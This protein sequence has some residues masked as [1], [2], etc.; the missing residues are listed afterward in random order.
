M[1]PHVLIVIG[2]SS[3]T[4]AMSKAWGTVYGKSH[5]PST[6]FEQPGRSNL[7]IRAT[8]VCTLILN[9]LTSPQPLTLS[10]SD[11]GPEHLEC[12]L[13][14]ENLSRTDW[15]LLQLIPG[16][17]VQLFVVCTLPLIYDRN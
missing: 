11:V 13:S 4:S 15:A 3:Y 14:F 16:I 6:C 2:T 12:T 5:P 7:Y 8:N 1:S 17:C 10:P 9:H